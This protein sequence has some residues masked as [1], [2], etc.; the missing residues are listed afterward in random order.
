MKSTSIATT[1]G[2]NDAGFFIGEEDVRIQITVDQL[3]TLHFANAFSHCIADAF[4]NYCLATFSSGDVPCCFKQDMTPEKVK[5]TCEE[6]L[7]F[8]ENFSEALFN[9][10]LIGDF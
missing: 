10:M 1:V 5:E 6:L 2:Y 8:K 3:N 7:Q 9:L 4:T